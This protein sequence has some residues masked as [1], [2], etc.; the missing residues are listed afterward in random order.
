MF[1]NISLRVTYFVLFIATLVTI[2]GI[3]S[4]TYG[5][6]IGD[7]VTGYITFTA[8]ENVTAADFTISVSGGS[9]GTISCGGSGFTNVGSS[10]SNCVVANLGGG[11]QSGTLATVTATANQAGTLSISASGTLSNGSGQSA[12]GGSLHGQSFT[13]NAPSA[14]QPTATPRPAGPTPT[15]TPIP[16]PTPTPTPMI[17]L[18]VVKPQ[19]GE[20]QEL[21]DTTITLENGTFTIAFTPASLTSTARTINLS[22]GTDLTLD[23]SD[24]FAQSDTETSVHL[25]NGLTITKPTTLGAISIT[26]LPETTLKSI[27]PTSDDPKWDG[28]LPLLNILE[29][30]VITGTNKI[31]YY[32]VEVG[33]HDIPP[34]TFDRPITIT[35]PGQS[36]K[37]AGY[38]RYG[39]VA[40]ILTVCS[41]DVQS[42]P[43]KLETP[44][45]YYD[46]GTDLII[47]TRHLTRFFSYTDEPIIATDAQPTSNNRITIYFLSM[48]L[49]ILVL[50]IV[51]Y[52]I[53]YKRQQKKERNLGAPKN[54]TPLTP[55]GGI[56]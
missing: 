7:T 25:P 44:D 12:G 24:N 37:L 6:N 1:R 27:H 21:L 16:E 39:S 29:P 32:V 14:P 31:I 30:D 56:Q 17:D 20:A 47:L 11:A 38:D 55:P 18:V 40:G 35:L 2:S 41:E 53:W 46:N 3:F 26:F 50:L 42:D 54:S 45:C 8:E 10:G 52:I 4:Q 51:G 49:A 15:P 48:M 22:E 28:M 33:G 13:I 43:S 9:V 34:I 36:G 5:E 23:F 19:E